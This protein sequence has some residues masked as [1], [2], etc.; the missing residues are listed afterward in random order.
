MGVGKEVRIQDDRQSGGYRIWYSSTD[1]LTAASYTKFN[2]QWLFQDEI[3]V[4]DVL[5]VDSNLG[6]FNENFLFTSVRDDT[7]MDFYSITACP[8]ANEFSYKASEDGVGFSDF[9]CAPC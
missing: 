9:G 2:S 7:S 4:Y 8:S 3:K 5:G 6:K 1:K